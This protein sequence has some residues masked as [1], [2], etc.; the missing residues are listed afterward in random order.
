MISPL[1]PMSSEQ[2]TTIDMRDPTSA[3]AESL[4]VA[5]GQLGLFWGSSSHRAAYFVTATAMLR[6]L[7]S[8]GWKLER[9]GLVPE[10]SP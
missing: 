8:R 5:E 6:P 4:A 10:A 2:M 1:H 7:Q 3:L 9:I